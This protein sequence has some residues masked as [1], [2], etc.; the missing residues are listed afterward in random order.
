MK[1]EK[2]T[3]SQ[4][5]KFFRSKTFFLINVLVLFFLIFSFGREFVRNYA[6]H[7]QISEMEAKAAALREENLSISTLLSS[8]Q[9]EAYIE[10]EARLKL[11]KMKPGEKIVV[12]ESQFL[13]NS[14]SQID[15]S[16][17]VTE[18]GLVEGGQIEVA[19]PLK[20]WYYFFDPIKFSL[21][22]NNYGE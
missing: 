1:S 11:D 4:F 3:A 21:L 6:I 18:L 19:N 17:A 7:Q 13:E 15:N 2:L 9:T 12:I 22:I 5:K 14:S 20:W 10:R 16:T 8:I